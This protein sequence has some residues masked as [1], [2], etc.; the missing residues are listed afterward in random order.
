MKAGE[1]RGREGGAGG[2]VVG[3]SRGVERIDS[4][5]RGKNGPL[6]YEMTAHAHRCGNY[7]VRA[8]LSIGVPLYYR[9]PIACMVH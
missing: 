8:P 1:E 7:N 4:D 5:S 2:G 6:K 3:W 9:L